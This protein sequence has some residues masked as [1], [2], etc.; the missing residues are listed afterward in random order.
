MQSGAAGQPDRQASLA[1]GLGVGPKQLTRLPE[2]QLDGTPAAPPFTP[3]PPHPRHEARR[4]A[5]IGED[6]LLRTLVLDQGTTRSATHRT[7]GVPRR[8]PARPSRR[9]PAPDR[10]RSRVRARTHRAPPPRRLPNRPFPGIRRTF[11]E[12]GRFADVVTVDQARRVPA[13]TDQPARPAS[14]TRQVSATSRCP[15]PHSAPGVGPGPR[16]RLRRRSAGPGTR[17]APSS[18]IRGQSVQPA[19]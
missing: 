7:A 8:Q 3:L 15:S 18:R 19:G 1:A 9:V 17:R 6:R 5:R 10:G 2:Q 16:A 11:R 14:A 12:G 13:G 4:T